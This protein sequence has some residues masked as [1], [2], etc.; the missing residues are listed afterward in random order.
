M[1]DAPAA[2]RR[3][4]TFRSQERRYALP[5]EEVSEVIRIPALARVP[6]APRGLLG[7]GNLRGTVLPVASLRGLLGQD[8]PAATTPDRA[9]V[10]D[11]PAPMAL[12]VDGVEGLATIAQDRLETRQAE[13]AAA[14]G[15]RLRGAFR[16]GTGEAFVGILDIESLLAAA[17]VRRPR[18][19]ASRPAGRR[20][21]APDAAARPDQGKTLVTFDVAGQAFGLS[22]ADV[23][24]ITPAPSGATLLPR[25]DAA[26]LGV[27]S[28]REVLLPLLSLRALLGF[29]PAAGG[30]GR[31][32]V[33]VTRVRGALVGLVADAM[34]DILRARADDIEAT[35]SVLAARTG[36]E[37]RIE[38][39]YHGGEGHGDE[40]RRLI[41]ILAPELL[42]R[43][44]VM[45]R[46]G[47]MGGDASV[48]QD[49]RSDEKAQERRILVFRLGDDEFALPIEAIDEVSALPERIAR[50]PRTP[51]FLEGVV[52]LRGEV[53]PVVDQRR[54]FGMPPAGHGTRRR[55]IV[56]RSAGHRAGL[57]VDGVSE[58][59]A[60][61]AEQIGPGPDL[62]GETNALVSGVINLEGAGRM[63]M[64][65]DPAELLSRAERGQLDKLRDRAEPPGS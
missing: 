14:P 53:L 57:I 6:Q 25:S 33:L 45:R 28:F 60:L 64:L 2:P 8:E 21:A 50:V 20:S 27:M 65:L 41:P 5:A 58:V 49:R 55:M 59:L 18:S 24:A 1:A 23:E 12:A 16:E 38:A 51:K 17:F 39:I 48:P 44:D 61:A 43:E 47:G 13:L 54:R 7:L 19:E 40:G 29:G 36:G 37:A 63:V 46:L 52:N 32:K 56:V 3:Y 35:P 22:L 42:F 9:L 34:R 30:D 4:L 31:E 62:T 10:L 15:E 11:G 26:V